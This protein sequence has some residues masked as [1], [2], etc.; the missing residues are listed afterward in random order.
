MKC[1]NCEYCRVFTDDELCS[2]AKC[3]KTSGKGK[4]ITWAMTVILRNGEKDHGEDRVRREL[5]K[6]KKEPNWCPLRKDKCE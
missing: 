3:Y 6:D 1:L 4:Q 5:S 2:K